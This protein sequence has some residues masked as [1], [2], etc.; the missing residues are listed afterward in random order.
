MSKAIKSKKDFEKEM[1]RYVK[2]LSNVD[3]ILQV[4]RE[5]VED[6][7]PPVIEEAP[8]PFQG[9]VLPH[10][11]RSFAYVVLETMRLIS[12]TDNMMVGQ[13]PTLSGM[14]RYVYDA[15]K[16]NGAYSK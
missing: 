1:R 15:L 14:G 8:S 13:K 7:C 11:D 4:L 9:Y 3:F 6:K 2:A 10:N 12:F 5:V 16:A